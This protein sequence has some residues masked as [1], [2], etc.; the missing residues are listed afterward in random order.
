[1]IFRLLG[2]LITGAI[3][4]W[5]AGGLMGERSTLLRNIVVG[6]AGSFVGGL[7]FNLLGFYAFGFFANLFVSIVGACIFIW[8][9][10]KLFR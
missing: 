5:I 7:V 2:T 3:V 9:G 1:M 4:G 8:L 6:V 10:R